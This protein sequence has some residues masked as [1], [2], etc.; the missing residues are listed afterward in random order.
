MSF[1]YLVNHGLY[2][3]MFL[4]VGLLIV[5]LLSTYLHKKKEVQDEYL[6]VNTRTGKTASIKINNRI[7]ADEQRRT[8]C[9]KV[10][11]LFL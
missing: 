2:E 4:A 6:L 8:L 1:Q 11:K 10:G 3:M 9:E 5:G 7:P